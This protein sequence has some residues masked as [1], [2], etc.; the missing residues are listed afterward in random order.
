MPANPSRHWL[1]LTVVAAV[2][3]LLPLAA[4][5]AAPAQ[6]DQTIE[7]TAQRGVLSLPA[8]P[9]V[10]LPFIGGGEL[11]DAAG[12]K[13][14][15]GYSSCLIAKIALPAELTAYCTSAFRLATG[16]IH[17]S[18]L[19]TYALLPTPGFQ[20][21][22][23][24]VIGGTGAYL[25]ARGEASTVKQAADPVDPTKVSYKFTIKLSA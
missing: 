12:K 25:T 7:L 5:S 11:L 18:S 8:A 10:G 13:V 1:R 19:R 23:M 21:G 22:P 15:E 16:E 2:A 17:L 14:G 24:A 4:A 9:A 6:Q 20:D 3:A